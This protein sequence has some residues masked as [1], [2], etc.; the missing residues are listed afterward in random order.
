M[1]ASSYEKRSIN[2]LR[3]VKAPDP[4]ANLR[5][6][7]ER[8]PPQKLAFMRIHPHGLATVG[9]A[10]GNGGLENPGVAALQGALF[11][12][13]QSDTFHESDQ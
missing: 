8:G 12:F 6:R 4:G 9:A 10:F 2:A 7:A 11:A 13:A 5:C 3:F 1:C